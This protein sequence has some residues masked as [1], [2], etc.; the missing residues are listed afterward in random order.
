MSAPEWADRYVGMRYEAGARGPEAFDCWGLVKE[1]LRTEFGVEGFEEPTEDPLPGNRASAF[2]DALDGSLWREVPIAAARP[3]D[4]LLLCLMGAPVHCGIVTQAGTMLHTVE[5]R[6]AVLQRYT[7]GVWRH[8][9]KGCY[10]HR[11][12]LGGTHA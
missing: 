3:G 12:L 2:E 4:V 5:G 11:S 6:N 8:R 9:V 7:L 10:R 1:V